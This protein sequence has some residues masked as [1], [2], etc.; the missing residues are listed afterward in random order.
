MVYG[1]AENR[2]DGGS[3]RISIWDQIGSFASGIGDGDGKLVG[4]GKRRIV[5]RIKWYPSLSVSAT[6]VAVSLFF[7][8]LVAAR[9][10]ARH[11]SL[12]FPL[13]H[14]SCT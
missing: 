11:E 1:E 6:L 8:P 5:S 3:E 7:I 10:P 2:G 12:R 9:D 14:P 4:C 13:V